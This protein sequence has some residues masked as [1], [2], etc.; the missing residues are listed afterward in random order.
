MVQHAGYLASNSGQNEI[1]SPISHLY[2]LAVIIDNLT[3]TQ[4]TPPMLADISSSM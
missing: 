3:P 2:A 1:I 4:Q